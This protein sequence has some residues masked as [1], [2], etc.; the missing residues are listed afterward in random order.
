MAIQTKRIVR[1]GSF[2]VLNVSFSDLA[3]LMYAQIKRM[4]MIK[5]A[6]VEYISC[7]PSKSS[8]VID[9]MA[10]KKRSERPGLRLMVVWRSVKKV[11]KALR[12]WPLCFKSNKTS[13]DI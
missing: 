12:F 6:S 4:A 5:A 7:L 11:L 10:G 3:L 1:A 8:A 13:G 2:F 9:W